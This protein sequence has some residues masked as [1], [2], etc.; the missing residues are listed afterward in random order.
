MTAIAFSLDMVAPDDWPA[1]APFLFERNRADGDV[2]CL[3]SN[4]GLDAGAYDEELRSL[5]PGDALYVV[6]RRD[7]RLIGAAGAEIDTTLGRS[8]LRGPFVAAGEDFASVA[9]P[10]LSALTRAMPPEIVR[11]DAFVQSEC[12]EALAFYAAQGYADAGRHAEFLLKGPPTAAATAPPDGVAL[13]PPQ[14]GWRLPIGALHDSEFPTGYVTTDELFDPEQAQDAERFTRIALLDG[15]PV[16]YVHA[17][18]DAQWHEGY[19]DYLAV[20]PYARGRGVGQALLNGAAAWSFGPR[21]ARAITLT[22]DE[23]RAA[24]RALYQGAGFMHVRTG[25]D[26]RWP[27]P[28]T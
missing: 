9:A 6:A 16:G 27:A 11:H 24:A 25:V 12:A 2:R 21:A 17:H 10:L 1:L 5:V 15:Q 26:M 19:I 4:A 22:V 20:A 28:S 8:W 3:H 7:G 23:K 14:P 13:M 18:F